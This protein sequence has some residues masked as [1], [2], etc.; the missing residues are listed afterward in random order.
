MKN[1]KVKIKNNTLILF[2][3]TMA[4]FVLFFKHGSTTG[5]LLYDD[6]STVVLSGSYNKYSA[7]N[8][9]TGILYTQKNGTPNQLVGIRISDQ[10]ELYSYNI[11]SNG[12]LPIFV[13]NNQQVWCVESPANKYIYI[14]SNDLSLTST[15][16]LKTGNPLSDT[17][18]MLAPTWNLE[19]VYLIRYASTGVLAKYTI[20]NLDG[21]D[22]EWSQNF[23]SYPNYVFTDETG[24][25]YACS[26]LLIKKYD[27]DSGS[28]LWSHI[29]YDVSFYSKNTG[30][31]YTTDK[32]AIG[33]YLEYDTDGNLDGYS[34]ALSAYMYPMC[35]YPDAD[36][37]FIY[38][39]TMFK[40][41]GGIANNMFKYNNTDWGSP[42]N[43]VLSGVYG[44][45]TDHLFAGDCSGYLYRHLIPLIREPRPPWERRF[46]IGLESTWGTGVDSEIPIPVT[47][48]PN[49]DINRITIESNPFS[50][51]SYN[52]VDVIQRLRGYDAPKIQISFDG[53]SDY[54]VYFFYTLFQR[55]WESGSSPYPKVFIP[56]DKSPDFAAKSGSTSPPL[57]S[58]IGDNRIDNEG[59]KIDGALCSNLKFE[60]GVG[61]TLRVTAVMQGRD[62]VVND[63]SSG[64]DFT[65]YS[66]EIPLLWESVVILMARQGSSTGIQGVF[67]IS[68]SDISQVVISGDQTNYIS[69]GN[70]LTFGITVG[71]SN[72]TVVVTETAGSTVSVT[73]TQGV[74]HPIELCL[75]L[76][77][78]INREANLANQ[79]KVTFDIVSRK[80]LFTRDS[81]SD[82]FIIDEE[83]GSME[84]NGTLGFDGSNDAAGTSY[85]SDSAIPWNVRAYEITNILANG[86]TTITVS[87][88]RDPTESTLLQSVLIWR[89]INASSM[90]LNLANNVKSHLR[91]YTTVRQHILGKF[92]CSGN[93]VVPWGLSSSDENLE[94]NDF[95]AGYRIPIW[96]YWNGFGESDNDL[97]M[98]LN[99]Y[100][101]G[102]SEIDD[103][104]VELQL[105]FEA[106]R[107]MGTDQI[108]LPNFIIASD[109]SDK[110]W[111]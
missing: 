47:N 21:G 107:D 83:N 38:T 81:G 54:L 11:A 70:Y 52:R 18:Y 80:F 16:T 72:D 67:T 10:A 33:R 32:Y 43:P 12:L 71:D 57:L 25:A 22:A 90:N 19:Y 100:Y 75:E 39:G 55:V 40:S 89:K 78:K 85:E 65:S 27:K 7:Y 110:S 94:I 88:D 97:A 68:S 61:Q 77:D 87:L 106:V 51:S 20:A 17:I 102:S 31:I 4:N 99:S 109:G 108:N 45:I 30:K 63:S 15:Y 50:G 46:G 29:G 93:F 49:F 58:I 2:L 101:V 34:N 41:V 62:M 111:S 104:A 56:Y 69:N 79:Y 92:E 48:Y 6:L 42:E 24:Y 66:T 44:T 53:I 5:R 13:D 91:N 103:Q 8:P 105:P 14:F 37:N 64:D 73:I 36:E 1:C 76:Q 82:T 9:D 3:L 98:F 96:I 28:E 35:I 26:A 95:I 60:C 84:M 86:N 59:H 74:Y 23:S